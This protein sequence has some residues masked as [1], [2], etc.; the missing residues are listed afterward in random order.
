MKKHLFWV[1]LIF[2]IIAQAL[3]TANSQNQIRF[4]ELSESIRNVYWFQKGLVFSGIN[5]HLGWYF[6]LSTIYSL[7]GFDIF[8]AKYFRLGL[9]VISLI[10][11]SFLLRNYFRR[12]QAFLIPLLAIG[13]SPTLLFFNSLTAQYG[14]DLQ[15]LPISLFL[16]SILDFGGFILSEKIP[17]S[18]SGMKRILSEDQRTTSFRA[19]FS[20]SVI[21]WGVNML[22]WSSYPTFIYYLPSLGFLYFWKMHQSR[23]KIDRKIIFM[24]I[25]AI[26]F[27]LPLLLM[28]SV[29]TNKQI[30]IHDQVSGGGLF[31]GAGALDFDFFGGLNRIWSTFL[32]LFG[33]ASSYH[34]EV[35]LA[36][37]SFI[38]PFASVIVSI[39][40]LPKIWK[41]EPKTRLVIIA[42]FLVFACNLLSLFL[43][44]DPAGDSSVRRAT[45]FLVAFYGAYILACKFALSTKRRQFLTVVILLLLPLHHLLVY[46]INLIHISD[47]SK[48]RE[49]YWFADP[50]GPNVALANYLKVLTNRDLE[51][52]FPYEPNKVYDPVVFEYYYNWIYSA[53]VSDC[54][55]N[56]LFCHKIYGYDINQKKF[57]ELNLGS[58]N[59]VHPG[60]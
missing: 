9:H 17:T 55:W 51:L 14:I 15:Y 33:F 46:P 53:L 32:G 57:R 12:R 29:I 16:L 39:F 11:L 58:V 6:S 8:V 59:Y 1:I 43:S 42:L 49:G 4:E 47:L 28:A 40:L 22:A 38:L 30:L 18:K 50:G 7:F 34:Y 36:D 3:F 44:V 35:K 10:C 5:A 21:F 54:Y 48:F 19:Q 26:S 25:S 60:E 31:R 56:G 13:L 20:I 37:F 27:V 24:A 2:L 41:I 52:T 45:G 23:L